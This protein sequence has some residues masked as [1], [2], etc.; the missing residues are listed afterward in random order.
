MALLA[1]HE[2]F[3]RDVDALADAHAECAAD[4]ASGLRNV[5]E[6]FAIHFGEPATNAALCALLV[7]F[8]YPTERRAEL[9]ACFGSVGWRTFLA[10]FVGVGREIDTVESTQFFWDSLAYAGQGLAPGER[11]DSRPSLSDRKKRIQA[12]LGLAEKA[13]TNTPSIYRDRY[14]YVWKGV[15]ARAALDSDAHVPIEGLQ[16]LPG[17]SIAAVRNAISSGTLHPNEDGDVPCKEAKAWLTRRRAFQPSRWKDLAD[18]QWPFDPTK[19]A[20]PDDKGMV[21]VPQSAD[22]EPFVPKFVVRNS[23]STAGI[24]ITVGAKGKEVQYNEFYEALAALA[25]MEVA[26]WRRRNSVGNWGIVRARGAWI[27]IN[28]ADIDRQLSGTPPALAE[29]L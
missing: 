12:L 5:G 22:G 15:A 13:R 16:L 24:S 10:E 2:L 26:R 8:S 9:R 11:P 17:V 4:L 19:A 29:V 23:L 28:K 27:A 3:P 20:T 21:L 25:K 1:N 14:D 6:A 7:D 18:N